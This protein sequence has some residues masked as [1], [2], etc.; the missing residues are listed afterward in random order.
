MVEERVAK[1]VTDEPSVIKASL[2]EYGDLVYPDSR[3]I[4]AK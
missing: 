4:L 3:S 2:A 1:L